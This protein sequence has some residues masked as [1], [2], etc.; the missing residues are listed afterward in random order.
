MYV[1]IYMY[2]YIYI[3]IYIYMYIYICVCEYIYI[4]THMYIYIYTLAYMSCRQNQL[5][6][7]GAKIYVIDFFRG[8]IASQCFAQIKTKQYYKIAANCCS[9]KMSKISFIKDVQTQ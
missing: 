6:M 3:C 1:Y 4:Y 2:M 8:P 9:S 5:F 7:P